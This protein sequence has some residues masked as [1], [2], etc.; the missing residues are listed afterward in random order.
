M[1]RGGW[2]DDVEV[3]VEFRGLGQW[4]QMRRRL[5]ETPGVEDLEVGQMSAR[6]ASVKLRYPGGPERLAAELQPQ[7]MQ[8]SNHGGQW[9]LQAR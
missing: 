6:S 9:V 4:Q 5:A 8:L 7:G 2:S 1:P 3:M